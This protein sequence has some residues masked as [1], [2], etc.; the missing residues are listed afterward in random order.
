MSK[1]VMLVGAIGAEKQAVSPSLNAV[2]LIKNK[3]QARNRQI[4]IEILCLADYRID[5]CT[6]CETCHETGV[7]V[8]EDEMDTLQEALRQADHIMIVSPVWACHIPGCL[9]NVM[10]RLFYWRHTMQLLGKTSSSV[11]VTSMPVSEIMTADAPIYVSAY[12]EKMLQLLGSI[13]IRG[14]ELTVGQL[15]APDQNAGET[16]ML[17]EGLAREIERALAGD[18]SLDNLDTQILTFNKYKEIYTQPEIQDYRG[19]AWKTTP[20]LLHKGF[21]DAFSCKQMAKGNKDNI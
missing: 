5:L 12:L 3:L 17:I 4:Q 7:C 11:A 18:F 19:R 14:I 9:K 8:L 6:G 15:S 10:D 16:D 21:L 13:Y 1:I 20:E 2:N